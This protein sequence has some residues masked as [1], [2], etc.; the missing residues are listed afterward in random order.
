MRR[1]LYLLILSVSGATQAAAQLFDFNRAAAT[2]STELAKAMPRFAKEVVAAYKDEDRKRYLDNLF[3]LQ[4]IAGNYG[5]AIVAIHSLRELLSA[6]NSANASV[7]YT[8]YEIFSTARILQ[9]AVKGSFEEAFR[10]A[11]RA[12]YSKLNDKDAYTVCYRLRGTLA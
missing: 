5:Q 10:Q 3:R 6:S 7:M 4:M 1:L 12:A 11:F 9:A 8:Q 2:D